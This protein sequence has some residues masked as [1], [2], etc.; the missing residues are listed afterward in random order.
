MSIEMYGERG[1]K[2]GSITAYS[3]RRADGRNFTFTA[4]KELDTIR[5]DQLV[6][7][8]SESYPN[9]LTLPPDYHGFAILFLR[10]AH[11]E[12]LGKERPV[13]VIRLGRDW[14]S[15]N[16]VQEIPPPNT[17]PGELELTYLAVNMLL[18]NG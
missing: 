17:Y 16:Y 10:G 5:S 2:T 9:L 12:R 11:I 18:E 13:A 14:E 3:I 4:I 15:G 6:K 1:E 8:F 7:E